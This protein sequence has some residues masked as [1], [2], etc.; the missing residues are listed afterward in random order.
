MVVVVCGPDFKISTITKEKGKSA[1]STKKEENLRSVIILVIAEWRV[2]GL[3]KKGRHFQFLYYFAS[4][5]LL[6]P[7][8]YGAHPAIN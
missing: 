6:H 7:K 4:P 5:L 3:A 8:Y 1:Q 2:E